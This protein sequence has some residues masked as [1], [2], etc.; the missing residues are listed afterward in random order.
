MKRLIQHLLLPLMLLTSGVAVAAGGA[1]NEH[2]IPEVLRYA[3]EYVQESPPRPDSRT[4]TLK[5]ESL[6]QKLADSEMSRRQQQIKLAELERELQ[7]LRETLQ[8]VRKQEIQKPLLEE[9][10]VLKEKEAALQAVTQSLQKQAGALEDKTRD[11]ARLKQELGGA[12]AQMQALTS[13]VTVLSGTN[14]TLQSEKIALQASLKK[15]LEEANSLRELQKKNDVELKAK[16]D[17]ISRLA[18]ELEKANESQKGLTA[19]V[20]GM[21]KQLANAKVKATGDTLNMS[22]DGV[23]QAYATGVMYARDVREANEGNQ[24]LGVQTDPTALMAGLS[25]ALAGRKL[26]LNQAELDKAMR[27]IEAAAERG[28]RT[29]T[30][31]Q[32]KAAKAY[33]KVFRK[34]KGTTRHELGFWYQVSYPGDGVALTSDDSV[35]VV[36]EETLTDG[37]VISDMETAGNSL[38]QAVKDFPPVFTAVLVKL[39]NHG[40]VTLVVPPELAY[41]DRGYPPKVPPGATMVYKLRVLNVI[42]T[43][44]KNRRND[45]EKSDHSMASKI[46][47]IQK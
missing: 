38:R 43:E 18:Q 3:R 46:E 34:A 17:D 44:K 47:E 12:T 35:D 28:F 29:V 8:K 20:S 6:K 42:P 21:K 25:D 26:Q 2:E 13:Q 27:D 36:V 16:D 14:G 15:T 45:S 31:A 33:L 22:S 39:R 11:V 7:S 4:T 30:Q 23:R 5:K 1:Q 32:K 40:Q 9:S 37:T 10:T 19:L 41:G 24:M